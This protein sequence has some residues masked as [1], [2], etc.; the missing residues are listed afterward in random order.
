[1]RLNQHMTP[2]VF[3]I[4]ASA[5]FLP[6][7][8]EALTGGRLG[9]AS[10][11]RRSARA[12]LGDALSADAARLPA[13]A[14]RFSR[15]PQRR[16]RDPAAHRRDRR[17]RRGRDRIRRGRCGRHRRRCARVAASARPARTPPPADATGHQMGAI[18]RASRRERQSAGRPDA[19]GGLRARRRSG[20]ADRRH[21][22]AR[23]A[24][25]PARRARARQVRCLLAAHAEV[26]ADRARS[27]ASRS[28][29]SA[30]ASRL[31]SGA[32]R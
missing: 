3:T 12:R 30:I 5:P 6:T 8:I 18:A 20:A 23:R 25:G 31:S 13:D 21:D 7:L 32:T 10:G 9:F 29:K 17:H 26:P 2:R 19:G 24:M 27:M 1:M 4:P 16:R 22:D 15:R 11:G 28:C 14:R